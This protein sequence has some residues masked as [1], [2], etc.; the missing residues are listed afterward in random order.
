MTPHST[1]RLLSVAIGLAL[2]L[3][4]LLTEGRTDPATKHKDQK[5]TEKET[6]TSS[7]LRVPTN[8]YENLRNNI[9]SIDYY[10]TNYGIF[11]LNI[12]QNRAGGI[13]PRGQ[14]TAYIFGGGIWFGA[15]KRALDSVGNAIPAS[16]GSDSLRRM[17][18]IGYNP[19]SGASWMTPGRIGPDWRNSP[20]DNSPEGIN[21]YRIYYSTD[22]S[23]ETGQALDIED[24]QQAGAPWPIWSTHPDK[25]LK[26]NGYLG[27]YVEN[28]TLRNKEMFPRGPA[29]IS[30]E[31]VF[32]T[33]KDTDLNRYE[34]S[35]TQVKQ[36][37]YPIGIQVEQTEYSWG[38][39]DY[40]NFMFVKYV[41]IN[42]SSDTL[43]DCWM[44]PALDMDIG[45]AG[46]DRTK[47][48]IE[49]PDDDSLNL[50]VQWSE[51]EP[52]H[53]GY[54]GVDFLE[55]PAVD[56]EGLLRRDKIRYDAAEQLGL[57][58]FHNWTIQ[59][60]PRT[61]EERYDFMADRSR[62]V[63]TGPGD[64][65]FLMATG[66]FTMRP[67][68]TARVVVGI[69][70]AYGVG[71]VPNGTWQD[72]AKLLQLNRFAQTVYDSVYTVSPSGSVG[73]EAADRNTSLKLGRSYPVPA[74]A[75]VGS[76]R[77]TIEYSIAESAD[78]MLTII[79]A[80]GGQV[81]CRSLGNVMAGEHSIVV[82]VSALP[83][84]VYHYELHTAAERVTGEL[85]VLR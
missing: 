62:D 22:Y 67:G 11:G 3:S 36:M 16:D 66:P 12:L 20:A 84:G 2:L 34:I 13:W 10:T 26:S 63:D 24:L 85:V 38:F 29:I 31:D 27:D 8:V 73:A 70:F 18:V 64:K 77:A 49:N 61:P 25:T 57:Q 6:E 14:T 60:D 78:I 44:S 32:T 71:T 9:S 5:Q 81:E 40:A 72:M 39:G 75:A 68:D 56:D 69:A 82:D 51:T 47:I 50:G 59:T 42:R 76:E 80:E 46:N 4:P 17:S 79:D 19:N 58:T 21:N 15:R 54:V 83:A 52:Y 7:P 37:G 35:L 53:Y 55:S 74:G 65:R 1:S 28:R 30:G 33:Y 23:A 41:I 43:R 45:Q 48:A